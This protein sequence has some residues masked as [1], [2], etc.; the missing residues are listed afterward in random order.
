MTRSGRDG[1]QLGSVPQGQVLD[2]GAAATQQGQGQGPGQNEED[3]E[4]EEDLMLESVI[5]PAIA[6]VS[7]FACLLHASVNT[8]TLFIAKICPRSELLTPAKET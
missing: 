5:I 8:K 1:Q 7:L 2:Y 4:E 6:S 3:M